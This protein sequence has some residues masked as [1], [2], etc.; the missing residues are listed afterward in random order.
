[1]KAMA[2]LTLLLVLLWVGTTVSTV[3]DVHKRIIGGE[4]CDDKERLY[5]V[6]LVDQNNNFICGGSLINDQWVLT[7]AHCWEEGLSV[8]IGVHPG[9]GMTVRINTK[10]KIYKKRKHIFRKKI[11]DLMLLKLPEGTQIPATIDPADCNA[12]PRLGDVVQIAGHA[13]TR[14]DVDIESP[15][16]QCANVNIVDCTRLRQIES[17]SNTDY[18]HQHWFCG[19][20]TGRDIRD[21]DSG[22]G[23]VFNGRLYGL[24]AFSVNA[25]RAGEDAIGF[26]DIC[27]PGY[28][29]WI[30][31]TIANSNMK[32]NKITIQM[33]KSHKKKMKKK[34]KKMMKK[35]KKKMKK[36]MKKIKKKLKK[37]MKKIKKKMKKMKR[38]MKKKMK[39]G[40]KEIKEVTEVNGGEANGGE[41]NAGEANGGEA[42]GGEANGGEA[43]AGEANGGEANAGEA[44]AGEA[45]GGEANTEVSGGEENKEVGGGE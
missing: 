23:V 13:S 9:P 11:H 32:E 28:L 24:I 2:R 37:V 45:N 15:T 34:M 29:Q 12:K 39:K 19:Q 6:K 40:V 16:L 43:N 4:K 31:T 35:I 44:N 10:P 5:H 42:N 36:V 20:A 27:H 41:A 8:I 25:T 17:H 30:E 26:L 22:G 7:V 3:V 14:M 21:G 18:E 1:M 38:K 33:K